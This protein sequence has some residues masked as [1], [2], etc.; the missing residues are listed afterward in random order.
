MSKPKQPNAKKIGRP[1]TPKGH[2]KA[3]TLRIRVTPDEYKAIKTKAAAKGHSVSHWIRSTLKAANEWR[4]L[5]IRTLPDR[6]HNTREKY[7]F[8]GTL[9]FR[10]AGVPPDRSNL[11]AGNSAPA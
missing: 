5:Q 2:A 6:K 7:F 9:Y 8:E 1:P 11:D 4:E 10:S 3:S